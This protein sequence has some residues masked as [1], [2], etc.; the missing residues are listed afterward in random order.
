MAAAVGAMMVRVV[1]VFVGD[2]K[3]EALVWFV[4]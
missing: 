4:D 3:Y 2:D 1:G